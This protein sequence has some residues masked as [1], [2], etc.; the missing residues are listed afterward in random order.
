MTKVLSFAK[1]VLRLCSCCNCI[2]AL[3]KAF[4]VLI[5]CACTVNSMSQSKVLAEESKNLQQAYN[6]LGILLEKNK[7]SV[8][9]GKQLKKQLRSLN[10]ATE[11]YLNLPDS[12][13]RAY[14]KLPAYSTIDSLLRN[15]AKAFS[16]KYVQSFLQLNQLNNHI[17]QVKSLENELSS[18]Y[19]TDIRSLFSANRKGFLTH[20]GFSAA[21]SGQAGQSLFGG[22]TYYINNAQLADGIS[23]NNIPL[24]VV[25]SFQQFNDVTFNSDHIFNVQFDKDAFLDSYRK[26]LQGKLK[27]EDLIPKD[28]VLESA[29]RSAELTLQNELNALKEQY[30]N[31]PDDV[32]KKASSIK[33]IVTADIT[34]IREQI[35]GSI[36]PQSI[37]D[38]ERILRELELQ[39]RS[40]IAVDSARMN[41]LQREIPGDKS[42]MEVFNSI[43][44]HKKKWESSGLVKKIFA[45]EQLRNLRFKELLSNP[46]SIRQLAGQYLQ[47]GGIEKW[48]M[49]VNSLKGGRHATTLDKLSMNNFLSDGISMEMQS[50][51]KYL[52]VLFGR[53]QQFTSLYD[54]ASFNP[55]Q[56]Q[57]NLAMG[58]RLGKGDLNGTHSHI[59]IFSYNSQPLSGRRQVSNSLERSN[60]VLSLSNK[61]VSGPSTISVEVS[62]SSTRFKNESKGE[63][64]NQPGNEATQRSFADGL[65]MDVQYDANFEDIKLDLNINALVTGRD[66]FNPG[67]AFLTQ[68][69]K[70]FDLGAHKS[71]LKNQLQLRMR[72]NWRQIDF[73][74]L[75]GSKWRQHQLMLD[76]RWQLNNGKFVGLQYQPMRSVKLDNGA[77]YTMGVTDRL[78]ASFNFNK[79]IGRFTYSNLANLSHNRID[80][81][82]GIYNNYKIQSSSVQLNSVQSIAFAKHAVYWNTLFSYV[83]NKT[84][85]FYSNNLFNTDAGFT[86]AIAK[87]MHASSGLNYYSVKGWHAVAGIRQTLSASLGQKLQLNVFVDWR[88]KIK[89][90]QYYYHEPLRADC[91]VRYIF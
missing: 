27:P 49:M 30:K 33:D 37:A 73:A 83:Y 51:D 88:T 72:N 8:I 86:Y 3:P 75:S 69:L 14:A 53:Q 77:K 1:G 50:G 12:M 78:S 44:Q 22:S 74:Q 41:N 32:L 68:G 11:K 24:S 31:V 18:L 91:S 13:L 9:S 38:K 85:T 36:S 62:H 67:N 2:T 87:K 25:Y 76:A 89:E 80:Q 4:C 29:V 63:L 65:A 79:R 39:M 5:L 10:L 48:L 35:L 15:K 19:K 16:K 59:S 70:Q 47:T 28:A 71:F 61:L 26:K 81:S 52:F 66:Y 6:N 23:I 7:D 60:L 54:A 34:N 46:A 45:D 20:E 17:S 90:T 58:I 82:G 42:S 56:P 57:G 84:N 21:Y 43:E 55:L 64:V 40:G